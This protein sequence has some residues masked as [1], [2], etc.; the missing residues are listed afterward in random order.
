[1]AAMFLGLGVAPLQASQ[2]LGEVTWNGLD[3]E[4]FAFT[5]K[6]GISRVGGSYYEIQGQVLNTPEGL[7]IFS[8]G[9]VL[10][11][12][13]VICSLTLTLAS[14]SVLI[15]QV[16]INKTTN[17]GTFWVRDAYLYLPHGDER[18][19][20]WSDQLPV[21]YPAGGKIRSSLW[22]LG[23]PPTTGTLTVTSAPIPLASSISSQLPLLL[24]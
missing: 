18:L 24:E 23:E 10:V 6:A 15:M 14:K 17:N 13:N 20:S 4:G 3:D 1:M 8:G 19:N 21:D 11:G 9:G 12:D 22:E 16:T 2:Y 5:V 7:G